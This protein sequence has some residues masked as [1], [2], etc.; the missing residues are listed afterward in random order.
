MSKL[1]FDVETDG[2]KYTRIWCI[3]TQDIDT[4]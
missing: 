4:G 1:V 2:L 3:A